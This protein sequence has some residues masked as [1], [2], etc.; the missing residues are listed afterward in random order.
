MRNHGNILTPKSIHP[1]TRNRAISILLV[2]IGVLIASSK[3]GAQELYSVERF[4][5]ENRNNDMMPFRDMLPRSLPS[6]YS[7]ARVIIQAYGNHCNAYMLIPAGIDTIDISLIPFKRFPTM[8]TFRVVGSSYPRLANMAAFGP[9]FDP[10]SHKAFLTSSA[11]SI[12][13]CGGRV[14]S[15]ELSKVVS[16][17]PRAILPD[18]RKAFLVNGFFNK[19]RSWCV[20]DNERSRAE[21]SLP[22]SA[23]ICVSTYSEDATALDV[24]RSIVS[25]SGNPGR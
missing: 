10:F 17:S 11:V 18:G 13:S 25:Y 3:L 14:D 20:F 6:R 16:K 24:L 21:R 19:W 22:Q 7:N 8:D 15:P 5:N 1:S 4:R 23:F 9:S 12:M 2:F